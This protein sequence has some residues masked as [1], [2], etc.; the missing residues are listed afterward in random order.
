MS[1]QQEP[2]VIV[3]RKYK[4]D[5]SAREYAC[6]LVTRRPGLIVVRFAM[7]AGGE[8]F[9]APITIPPGSISY[10][11]FWA[12]RPY[13]LYRM[14]APDGALIAHRFDAVADVRLLAGAVE[15]R[16]LVLDWWVLPDDTILEEDRD[17]LDTLA[18][19]GFLSPADVAAANRA[20]FEVLSRYR[21]IID[22]VA[23]LEGKLGIRQ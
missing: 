8:I 15:Y 17:E 21:H 18:A 7:P 12:R 22:D 20:A 2:T 9:N 23:A 4:P 16:D 13:N 3:E 14:L 19:T 10:G 6:E 1:D 11:W 5:G